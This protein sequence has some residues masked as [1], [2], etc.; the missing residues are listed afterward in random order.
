[1]GRKLAVLLLLAVFTAGAFATLG[2]GK[3]KASSRPKTSFLSGRTAVGSGYFS[4]KS[5]YSFRGTQVINANAE[6][7]YFNL[8]T[9][10]TVQKGKTTYVLPL[11]KKV[12][13]DKVKIDLGNRQFKRN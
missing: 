1:M 6:K 7:K 3:K 11:R 4:L 13:I 9:V 10:V 8:N 2:D 12:I 5:G